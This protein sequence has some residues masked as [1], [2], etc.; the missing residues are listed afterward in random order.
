MRRTRMIAVTLSVVTLTATTMAPVAAARTVS[1]TDTATLKVKRDGNK[2]TGSGNATGTLPGRLTA[3]LTAKG[4]GVNGQVILIPRSGGSLTLGV[5]ANLTSRSSTTD[6]FSGTVRVLS[7][8]GVYKRASGKG[9]VSATLNRRTM[10][11]T[12]KVRGVRL[13]Y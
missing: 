5:G 8:T 11:A 1:V 13:T 7:G 12:V 6:S 9:P 10:I 3:Y 2:L 4:L